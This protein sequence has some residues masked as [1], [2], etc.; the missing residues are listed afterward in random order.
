MVS[1]MSAP[2][3]GLYDATV[4]LDVAAN[5]IANADTPGFQ[6]A[7]VSSVEAPG[8]GVTSSVTMAGPPPPEDSTALSGTDLAGEL[9]NLTLVRLAFMANARAVGMA[10][11]MPSTVLDFLA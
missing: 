5:N 8:G 10:S 4:R 6:P 7:V 3:S 9:L 2:L 11:D 1:A